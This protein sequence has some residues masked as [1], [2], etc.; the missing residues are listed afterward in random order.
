M[1]GKTIVFLPASRYMSMQSL[2]Q[3]LSHREFL[4]IGLLPLWIDATRKSAYRDQAF[5]CKSKRCCVAC[6]PDKIFAGQVKQTPSMQSYGR[7]IL[8]SNAAS[9]TLVFSSTSKTVSTPS[10]LIVTLWY[11]LVLLRCLVGNIRRKLVVDDKH[12]NTSSRRKKL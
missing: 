1:V 8:A 12:N 6:L 3:S 10:C 4:P 5:A 7:S 9:N 11:K 2:S